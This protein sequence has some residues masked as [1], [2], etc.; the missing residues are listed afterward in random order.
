MKKITNYL[1]KYVAIVLMG[2]MLLSIVPIAQGAE[3]TTLTAPLVCTHT[4]GGD[5]QTCQQCIALRAA[6]SSNTT[7]NNNSS[8]ASM[9]APW[10]KPAAPSDTT[11]NTTAATATTVAT[12]TA[13]ATATT[14][15]ATQAPA[16]TATTPVQQPAKPP[17]EVKLTE[18]EIP[19]STPQSDTPVSTGQEGENWP[20]PEGVQTLPGDTGMDPN[21]EQGEEDATHTITVVGLS[22]SPAHPTVG[23]TVLLTASLQGVGIDAAPSGMVAFTVDGET[24]SA[25][26]TGSSAS[27]F[28][29]PTG[30]GTFQASAKYAPGAGDVYAAGGTSSV[31]VTVQAPLVEEIPADP[32]A[33]YES[34]LPP[35]LRT[36]LRTNATTGTLEGENQTPGTTAKDLSGA[37]VAASGT[38]SYTGDAV[39]PTYSVTLD[40]QTLTENTDYR[41]KSLDGNTEVGTATITVEGM[42]DYSGEATGTFEIGSASAEDW[43]VTF[44]STT[45]QTTGSPAEVEVV[46]VTDGNSNPV[47]NTDYTLSYSGDRVNAGTFSAVL[48]PTAEAGYVGASITAITLL[49]NPVD[50]STAVI[51]GNPSYTSGGT[52]YYV[53]PSGGNVTPTLTV[54]VGSTTLTLTTDYTVTNGGP[55]NTVGPQTITITGVGNYTGTKT[56]ALQVVNPSTWVVTPNQLSYP[57]TGAKQEPAFTVTDNGTPVTSGFTREYTDNV[58]VGTAKIVVTNTATQEV[59][60]GTFQITGMTTQTTL[61]SQVSGGIMTIYARVTSTSGT[62]PTGT[63]SFVVTRSSGAQNTYVMNVVGGQATCSIAVGSDTFTVV[64]TYSGDTNHSGSAGSLNSLN[65][66]SIKVSV[67]GGSSGSMYTTIT[68]TVSGTY[69]G[70][71][72]TGTVIF[73]LDGVEIGRRTLDRYGMANYTLNSYTWG[74]QRVTVEYLGDSTYVGAISAS[75]PL[76]DYYKMI[77]T[78]KLTTSVG[79]GSNPTILTASVSGYLWYER[80]TGSVS[81]Y[82]GEKLLG[83]VNLDR[84]SEAA[85]TWRNV[86]SGTHTIYAVYN[87]DS[88]YRSMTATAKVTKRGSSSGGSSS[89]SNTTGSTTDP[90]DVILR[91]ANGTVLSTYD[92]SSLKMQDGVMALETTQAQDYYSYSFGLT[93]VKQLASNQSN[94]YFNMITPSF[95]FH[96]PY[97]TPASLT[98]LSSALQQAGV[99]E[100]QTELRVNIRRVSDSALEDAF[101][102]A[103]EG[104]TP[105][106]M[107]RV[108][109]AFYTSSGTRLNYSPT[110]ISAPVQLLVPVSSS[111]GVVEGYDEQTRSFFPTTTSFEGNVANIGVTQSG[112]YIV[113]E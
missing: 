64:G 56:Y 75:V 32:E 3:Q 5:P 33:V 30:S 95:N 57:Y 26:V 65:V 79:S 104:V 2:V 82:N 62:V 89:S 78:V 6:A 97:S 43:N 21:T 15:A 72:P 85:Y 19:L 111:N 9:P 31:G 76:W 96:L 29:Q 63:V 110:N 24:L 34:V 87:G 73:K 47:D 52:D 35:A 67:T 48:T 58:N 7:T 74:G 23:D 38:Y 113:G 101:K 77:P 1:R 39:V 51:T 44:E 53:L 70:I 91:D 13:T 84:N 66:P 45:L 83:T 59:A 86:P 11:T 71:T 99:T 93:R 40:S 49:A 112:I 102:N 68:T 10:D 25:S 28:W 94:G 88:E 103:H 27:V 18:Q 106:A 20:T 100:A 60:I 90:N 109:L 54:K 50:I 8:G 22:C 81:F 55:F 4:E 92:T 37:T 14:Q 36:L 42:G 17:E 105:K 16:A 69:L 61:T 12:A 41:L 46:S 108:E 107:Y 80:P 98:D